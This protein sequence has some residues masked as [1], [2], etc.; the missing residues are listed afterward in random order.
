M[1]LGLIVTIVCLVAA[2]WGID[3]EQIYTSFKRANYWTLPLMLAA[4]FMFYWL[5]AVRWQMLLEPIKKLTV[6]QVTPAMID[7]KSVV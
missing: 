4:L 6:A 5:K 7:R 1:L 2:V 3:F